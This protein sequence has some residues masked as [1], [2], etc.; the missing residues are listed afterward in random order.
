MIYEAVAPAIASDAEET[1]PVT[2]SLEG[3]QKDLTTRRNELHPA[4]R[5]QCCAFRAPNGLDSLLGNL[6]GAS[7]KHERS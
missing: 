7:F 4:T 2:P 6:H 5:H 3:C 1:R